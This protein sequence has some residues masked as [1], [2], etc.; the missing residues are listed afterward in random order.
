[1]IQRKV[2]A[3]KTTP[4]ILALAAL[5][6]PLQAADLKPKQQKAL[7]KLYEEEVLAHDLYV[8]LGKVHT[9][10]MPRIPAGPCFFPLNRLGIP[11]IF[12]MNTPCRHPSP[13]LNST[14]AS[15]KSSKASG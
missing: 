11:D 2:R 12:P 14:T 13:L 3:M 8:A 1:M 4:I 7:I 15:A 9:D 6:L 10:I 5:L